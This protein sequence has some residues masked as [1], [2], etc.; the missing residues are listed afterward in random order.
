[1]DYMKDFHEL[2]ESISK[3]ISNANEDIKAKNGKMSAGDLETIDKLTHSL[4]SLKT[5]VAMMEAED[6]N[7]NYDGGSYYYND[8][9]SY[10]RGR[11]SYKYTGRY[12]RNGGRYS[13]DDGMIDEL[14]QMAQEASNDQI[15]REIERLADKMEQM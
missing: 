9:R 11:N 7:S 10:A 4:K 13:R 5:A 6:G 15:K 1:M 8:G 14:R 2:C 3:E 12:G